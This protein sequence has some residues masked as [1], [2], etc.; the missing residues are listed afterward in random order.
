[1]SDVLGFSIIPFLVV[2]G[3]FFVFSSGV[4]DF[5]P[6]ALW[7]ETPRAAA[8]A[9]A[10]TA[11][12]DAVAA[13]PLRIAAPPPIQAP[14]PISTPVATPRTSARS[15]LAMD[16]RSGATLFQEGIN[17][18]IS[19][20]SLTKLATALAAVNAH[21]DWE[22][23]VTIEP[24][25]LR[26]GGIEYFIAGET[27]SLRDLLYAMLVGSSNTAAVAIARSVDGNVEAFA[28]RMQRVATTLSLK[29][30]TFVEPTG[31]D[32]RNVS[33]AFEVGVLAR[34]AFSEPTLKNI[35]VL[36][37]YQLGKR[38]VRSTDAL[39]FGSLARPPF[40]VL[41]GKT[42][43]L[44]GDIGYHL[45]TVID[46][47]GAGPVLIVVLGSSTPGARFSDAESLARWAFQNYQ[48]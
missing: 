11:S 28:S 24:G 45:A 40:A 15:A 4:V 38:T 17:A 32:E 42:G 10:K 19:I 12:A 8:A 9:P 47:D 3:A 35:L 36:P 13:K 18:P 31:L 23:N 41:A 33:T 21:P 5:H 7:S 44:G 48:W 26:G 29:N 25:D 30:T 37:S 20:A 22:K 27:Y 6:S 39:L 1:M 2:A 16:M 14:F 46:R 43:S 34:T